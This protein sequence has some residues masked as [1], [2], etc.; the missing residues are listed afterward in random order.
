MGP[1]QPCSVGLGM[2]TAGVAANRHSR[3]GIHR[4]NAV[5]DAPY[6]VNQTFDARR[7]RLN[8][9]GRRNRLNV[10]ELLARIC[11][12]K[13]VRIMRVRFGARI[14]GKDDTAREKNGRA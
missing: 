2:P 12:P 4:H 3:G 8:D 5:V 1:S 9:C 11:A 7:C 10:L 14:R 13:R 6:V